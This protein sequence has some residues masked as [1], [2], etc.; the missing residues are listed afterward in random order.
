MG[1]GRAVVIGGSIAGLTAA[2]AL[3]ES[4][5]RVVVVERDRLPD[6]PEHRQGVPQGRQ[7]HVVL[8]LGVR[9]LDD[10]FPGFERELRNE[11]CP[12]FDEVRDTPWFGGQGWRARSA[13][14]VHLFGF[15]RPL[16]EH[17]LRRRVRAIDAVEIVEGTV[18]GLLGDGERV[19]GVSISKPQPERLEAD[20]PHVL[21]LA[22][23]ARTLG[24]AYDG[25]TICAAILWTSQPRL[26]WINDDTLRKAISGM[27]A[28]T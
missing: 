17:L 10:L 8:P 3:S 2:R 4:F 14:D 22:S 21:Q 24:Q 19:T 23:Y 15:S 18:D 12:T 7:L 5:D 27:A 26:D 9:L 20:H 1:T 13:S 16:F 6:G 11:G 25:K 28:I